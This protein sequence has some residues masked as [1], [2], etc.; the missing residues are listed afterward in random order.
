M[1]SIFAA[2]IIF[3]A[4]TTSQIYIKAED[5]SAFDVS[6]KRDTKKNQNDHKA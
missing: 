4:S 1:K 3:V 5:L 6:P 2:A